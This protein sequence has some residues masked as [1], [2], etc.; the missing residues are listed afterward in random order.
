MVLG[1][2]VVKDYEQKLREQDVRITGE[3]AEENNDIDKNQIRRLIMP[4]HMPKMIMLRD[5][6]TNLVHRNSNENKSHIII[7]PREFQFELSNKISENIDIENMYN[8]NFSSPNDYKIARPHNDAF[9]MSYESAFILPSNR[10]LLDEEDH[11]EV[12]KDSSEVT[13]K[14]QFDDFFSEYDSVKTRR[15]LS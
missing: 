14:R 12:N 5:L 13:Q 2:E 4:N 6:D 9:M 1:K 8:P 3:V 10:V 15:I 7:S 11:H